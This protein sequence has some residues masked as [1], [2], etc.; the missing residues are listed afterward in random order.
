[1]SSEFLDAQAAQ[2]ASGP[3]AGLSGV[4]TGRRH[5]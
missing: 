1:M 2:Q 4:M 5:C 3:D